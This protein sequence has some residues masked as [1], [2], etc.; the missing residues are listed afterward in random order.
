MNKRNLNIN[1][2]SGGLA[3]T[4]N[5]P[6]LTKTGLTKYGEYLILNKNN[7]KFKNSLIKSNCIH[8]FT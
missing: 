4:F 2:C 8:I 3:R 5:P 6:P 1:N 7:G